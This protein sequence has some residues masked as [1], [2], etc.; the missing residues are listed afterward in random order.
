VM[1]K[2]LLNHFTY[3]VAPGFEFT[4]PL[5]TTPAMDDI[6]LVLGLVSIDTLFTRSWV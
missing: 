4:T 3:I 1:I 5:W 6:L 2:F